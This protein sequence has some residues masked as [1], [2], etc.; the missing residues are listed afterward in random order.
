MLTT[1]R[2]V[3]SS[4]TLLPCCLMLPCRLMHRS[5]STYRQLRG[6]EVFQRH[7]AKTTFIRKSNQSTSWASLTQDS[8]RVSDSSG[9]FQ[10]P[11]ADVPETGLGYHQ[12]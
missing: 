10:T 1:S 11:T 4:R 6:V 3:C 7:T 9:H 2:S 5:P 8:H 12:A